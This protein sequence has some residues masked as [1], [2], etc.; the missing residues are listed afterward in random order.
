LD[1][2]L[3]IYAIKEKGDAPLP[4]S[5]RGIDQKGQVFTYHYREIEAVVS[6]VSIQEY[7]SEEIQKNLKKILIGLKKKPSFMKMSLKR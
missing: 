4:L 6:R 5:L 2:G 1:K 7:T 3:Y